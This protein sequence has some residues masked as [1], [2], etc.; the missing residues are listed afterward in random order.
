MLLFV[1][2]TDGLSA[3]NNIRTDSNCGIT[4]VSLITETF[5]KEHKFL[6]WSLH[7]K[8]NIV[9]DRVLDENGKVI[10]EK[11]S[12]FISS[13]DASDTKKFNR[14]KIVGNE[15]WIFHHGK[16]FDKV[17]PIKRYDFCGNFLGTEIWE[18]GDYYE[19]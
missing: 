7:R 11:K 15:I 13:L 9:T 10:F 2:A 19:I 5:E 17:S 1:N 14:I 4:E 3:Q 6:F 16:N 8:K 18:D 12:V